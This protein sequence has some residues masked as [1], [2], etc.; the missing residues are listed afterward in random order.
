MVQ[1]VR[2]GTWYWQTTHRVHSNVV[3][4]DCGHGLLLLSPKK[5][6]VGATSWRKN[7]QKFLKIM[8][9]LRPEAYAKV[10]KYPRMHRLQR[11]TL[12][13]PIQLGTPAE[14][15]SQGQGLPGKL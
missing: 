5:V 7:W 15:P 8:E 6:Y 4:A 11:R 1:A 14:K 10:T 9:L 13:N 12:L 2:Y 3:R